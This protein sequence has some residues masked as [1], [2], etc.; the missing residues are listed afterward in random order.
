MNDSELQNQTFPIS[1]IETQAKS[2]NSNLEF[3][4]LPKGMIT[5]EP[6]VRNAHWEDGLTKKVF[7]RGRRIQQVREILGFKKRG[8]SRNVFQGRPQKV[9]R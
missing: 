4:I 1:K 7:G 3:E 2:Q 5:G 8:W 9:A 6:L